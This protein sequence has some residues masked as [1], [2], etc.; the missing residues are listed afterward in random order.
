VQ[1]PPYGSTEPLVQ[2]ADA[3]LP[4]LSPLRKWCGTIDFIPSR[5]T[6][7]TYS[8]GLNDPRRSEQAL[9]GAS[10]WRQSAALG[11][12]GVEASRRS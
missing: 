8:E 2:A 12:T 10:R 7:A 5:L 4:A 11:T 1:A 9:S 3:T 6:P